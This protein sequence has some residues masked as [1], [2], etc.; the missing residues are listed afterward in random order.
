MAS[1][2]I[3]LSG[4]KEQ[5]GP[6]GAFRVFDCC[7]KAGISAVALANEQ[8]ILV[9]SL[10]GSM[11][12]FRTSA[13]QANV[14]GMRQLMTVRGDNC[15]KTRNICL[16]ACLLQS[17]CLFLSFFVVRHKVQSMLMQN[18]SEVRDSKYDRNLAIERQDSILRSSSERY[19]EIAQQRAKL[20]VCRRE[21]MDKRAS[22]EVMTETYT[23]LSSK[24]SPFTEPSAD[25]ASELAREFAVAQMLTR[26]GIASLTSSYIVVC[27]PFFFGLL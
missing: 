2:T 13:S 24:V 18:V 20:D 25:I 21:L 10:A 1:T 17:H 26:E 5:Q 14:F 8:E 23:M 12:R 4:P 15:C 11:I 9:D 27:A 3:D 7:E 22:L 19:D 16:L 6:T